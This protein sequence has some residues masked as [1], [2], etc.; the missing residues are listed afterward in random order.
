MTPEQEK[1]CICNFPVTRGEAQLIWEWEKDNNFFSEKR[2][3][4]IVFTKP[5]TGPVETLCL[6]TSPNEWR[7]KGDFFTT[8]E[9]I[10][11]LNNLDDLLVGN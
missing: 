10:N 8:S 1:M 4:K 11:N 3:V 6:G 5:S 9:I 2:N 7:T